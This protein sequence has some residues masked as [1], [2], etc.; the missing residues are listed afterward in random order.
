MVFV[1]IMRD[2][3]THESFED[4]ETAA[5]ISKHSVNIKIDRD[6]R[7]DLDSMATIRW[8]IPSF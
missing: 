1:Q 6:E 4:P 5:F 7:S 2:I 8:L 3:F